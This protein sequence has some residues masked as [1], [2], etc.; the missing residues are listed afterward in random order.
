MQSYIQP[1]C[2]QMGDVPV[3]KPVY[4]RSRVHK[5][6]LTQYTALV[7]LTRHRL[8]PHLRNHTHVNNEVIKRSALPRQ[9]SASDSD[10]L[11][12][13]EDSSDISDIKHLHNQF[14]FEIDSEDSIIQD[15]RK[16]PTNLAEADAHDTDT[17]LKYHEQIDA[18]KYL[19]LWIVFKTDDE[20]QT[21]YRR[22]VVPYAP[23]PNN[24]ND[25]IATREYRC[26]SAM[27]SNI[28]KNAWDN[29]SVGLKGRD[30]LHEYLCRTYWGISRQEVGTIID[31]FKS[32]QQTTPQPGK[33][34]SKPIRP[35]GLG[36]H[37]IDCT[38]MRSF[39]NGKTSN[40][41]G[42]FIVIIDRFSR[43]VWTFPLN[44]N[45]KAPEQEHIARIL[46]LL[47]L[48]EGPPV[49][50]QS[51][52]GGEF[53]NLAVSSVCLRF[54]VKQV[55]SRSYNPQTN[56]AVERVN[57]T[58]KRSLYRLMVFYKTRKWPMYLPFV[59]HAYNINT[60]RVTGQSP[61]LVHR[62]VSP[63]AIGENEFST[64]MPQV[65][66]TSFDADIQ[67]TNAN[68]TSGTSSENG[69]LISPL[70]S[71]PIN[72][73]TIMETIEQALGDAL[74]KNARISAGL[75]H[76]R[77]VLADHKRR[78][79]QD[80][81]HNDN[82][83]GNTESGDDD[84]RD[85]VDDVENFINVITGKQSIWYTQNVDMQMLG[86]DPSLNTD[87][88]NQTANAVNTPLVN[89]PTILSAAVRRIV[90]IGRGTNLYSIG[91][92]GMHSPSRD[93][94]CVCF[95]LNSDKDGN[96]QYVWCPVR[97]YV[98]LLSSLWDD[99]LKLFEKEFYPIYEK[100]MAAQQAILKQGIAKFTNE[101][102][103]I[104][105]DIYLTEKRNKCTKIKFFKNNK[106]QSGTLCKQSGTS[107]QGLKYIVRDTEGNESSTELI[108]YDYTH[109]AGTMDGNWFII[110]NLKKLM[111]SIRTQQLQICGIVFK[112]VWKYVND[113]ND[114]VNIELDQAVDI[115]RLM[116]EMPIFDLAKINIVALNCDA[117]H[118][119]ATRSTAR[120][121]LGILL[122]VFE[123]TSHNSSFG[124]TS[125]GAPHVIWGESNNGTIINVLIERYGLSQDSYYSEHQ[126][127]TYYT[128]WSTFLTGRNPRLSGKPQTEG[129]RRSLR[130]ASQ[131]P[132]VVGFFDETIQWP[133][134]PNEK[135]KLLIKICN[136]F[137]IVHDDLTTPAPVFKFQNPND[138]QFDGYVT[139]TKKTHTF[140]FG[141]NITQL[142]PKTLG[143]FWNVV[144]GA[145]GTSAHV[146]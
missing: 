17:I 24:D 106:W 61:F 18:C 78:N 109:G 16:N 139:Y 44:N 58:L 122:P 126:Q 65:K 144:P 124:I 110:G 34:F 39:K 60:H 53:N 102:P 5:I 22:C 133:N 142:P 99:F 7:K 114:E 96:R 141:Y 23:P 48:R 143:A 75:E 71:L 120:V 130:L 45:N 30:K 69:P 88:R 104:Q 66:Y 89:N 93:E 20:N 135:K 72:N 132:D 85:D 35:Y 84:G 8:I 73:T 80:I 14:A 90:G 86:Y 77:N 25:S 100:V 46:T 123:D 117:S 47:W 94:Y 119:G 62:G 13:H 2:Y 87:K 49:I 32:K 137:N 41:I 36:H 101:E 42:G 40:G 113:T 129:D 79:K 67:E 128:T 112:D 145:V 29:P 136:E 138:P 50:L 9:N 12:D 118:T 91:E 111:D 55:F 98:A 6:S 146:Q 76:I 51:D 92:C 33:L 82:D 43:F 3:F 140:T 21:V 27:R 97:S 28:V 116:V 68:S 70:N 64:L 105:P 37:Q 1:A 38:F 125:L 95:E 11:S 74:V 83:D 103:S 131:V 59:T 108:I 115:N 57:Q 107:K 19:I 81:L 54:N 10:E 134:D 56:G 26:Y 31:M 127:K 4:T 15:I 52:N 121:I 63:G